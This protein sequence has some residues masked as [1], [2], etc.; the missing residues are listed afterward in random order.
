M[1]NPK[2]SILRGMGIKT[3]RCQKFGCAG[4]KNGSNTPI[5]ISS[6][7]PGWSILHLQ[8]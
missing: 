6:N 8:Q 3:F 4:V 5:L 1:N 2:G 7:E